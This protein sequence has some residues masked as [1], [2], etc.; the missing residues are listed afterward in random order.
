MSHERREARKKI[1]EGEARVLMLGLC[2]TWG[3][4]GKEVA[5]VRKKDRVKVVT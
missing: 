2:G 4:R 1:L 5:C 3:I